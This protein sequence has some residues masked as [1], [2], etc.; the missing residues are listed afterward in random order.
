MV[1]RGLYAA[2]SRDENPTTLHGGEPSSSPTFH[3]ASSPPPR[4]SPTPPR[5]HAFA[6]RLNDSTH[7]RRPMGA[8]HSAPTLPRNPPPLSTRPSQHQQRPES[9]R[10]RPILPPPRNELPGSHPINRFGEFTPGLLFTP[11]DPSSPSSDSEDLRDGIDIDDILSDGESYLEA[12]GMAP[13]TRRQWDGDGIV[14]LTNDASSPG[15]SS[16]NT[17]Q[18]KS[19]KRAADEAKREQSSKRRKGTSSSIKAEAEIEHLDLT[20]EAPSAEEELAAAQTAAAVLAQQSS[21]SATGP[22]KIGQMQCI[23]C[24]ESFTNATIT[25]CGHIYCHECLTQALNAGEKN[26]E[27]GKANCPVCRKQVTRK[28]KNQVIPLLFMK[29]SHSKGK[30]KR[31]GPVLG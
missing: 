1:C 11:S 30:A 24:M 9:I 29:K 7:S 20:N 13:R 19:R 18:P 4:L 26:S 10:R 3:T 2:L 12:G 22:L 8:N 25:H 16:S 6:G 23:I 31:R 15:D 5:N 21:T 14:D 27:S 17:R 28:N